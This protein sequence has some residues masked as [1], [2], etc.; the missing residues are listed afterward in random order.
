MLV[1]FNSSYYDDD[2][3]EIKDRKII[4][5]T[6]IK[7]WFFIDLLAVVPFDLLIGGDNINDIVRITRIGRMY[8]LIKLTR[9]LRVL[10]IVKER[11]RLFNYVQN[12]LKVGIGFERLFFFVCSFV[13]LI[14]IVACLW[15]MLN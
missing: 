14:H 1:I 5:L 8:K 11:S 13:I 2:Y 9:L 4:A 7:S 15:V 6:Y 12:F 3:C 10:K